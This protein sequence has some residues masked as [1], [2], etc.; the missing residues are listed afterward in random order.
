MLFRDRRTY[1]RYPVDAEA[2]WSVGRQEGRCR[3]RTLSWGGAEIAGVHASLV[4]GQRFHVTI[5]A[6]GRSLGTAEV[7][8]IRNAGDRLGLSFVR[9][10]DDLELG[11]EELFAFLTPLTE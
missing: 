5:L 4:V 2:V 9:L 7:E 11:L 3:I 6:S 1:A 10:D 8:V